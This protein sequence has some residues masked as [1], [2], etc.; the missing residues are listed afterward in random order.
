MQG[1]SEGLL[2]NFLE[3]SPQPQPGGEGPKAR[4]QCDSVCGF[5]PCL[6][7]FS[8]AILGVGMG[9]MA[10][11]GCPWKSNRTWG[12]SRG[13]TDTPARKWR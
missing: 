2:G 12:R 11:L 8:L 1:G 6:A 4:W 3:A 9:E 13:E 10:N 5:E 7:P